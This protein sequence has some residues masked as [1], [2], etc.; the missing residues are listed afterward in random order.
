MTVAQLI[1]Q[2]QQ[3]NADTIVVG[4]DTVADRDVLFD[5]PDSAVELMPA[6][7]NPELEQDTVVLFFNVDSEPVY[8]KNK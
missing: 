3:F 1:A 8:N 2:L 4:Y 6:N 7:E 5:E